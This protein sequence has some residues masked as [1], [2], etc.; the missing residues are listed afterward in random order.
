M[1]HFNYTSYAAYISGNSSK[2]NKQFENLIKEIKPDVVHHHNISLLGYNLLKK[3]GNYRNIYTAHDYWLICQQNNLL[4]N[5]SQICEPGSSCFSCALR[6]KKTPQLWRHFR[7]FKS[8]IKDIDVIVAPSTYVSS[9]L[10]QFL[11]IKVVTLPNFVPEQPDYLNP[12]GFSNYFL[13]TGVLE[14]HKG[15][16]D[17]LEIYKENPGEINAPLLVVGTGSLI[18]EIKEF[19]NRNNLTDKVVFLG[20]VDKSR[21]YQLLMDANAFITPSIWPENCPLVALEALSTG[22]PVIASKKGG[23]PEIIE[24]VDSSLLYK[25]KDELKHI[26][27]NFNSSNYPRFKIKKVYD[28]NYSPQVFLKAY[29]ERVLSL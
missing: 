16:K 5:C 25:S 14:R 21:L 1:T 10:S 8:A 22:T 4:K 19:V 29:F 12:S 2:V 27:T 17:L 11:G 7:G 3:Q 20:Q 28:D 15:I 9:L 13:Y 23:L 6:C 24:K 26:L 18:G